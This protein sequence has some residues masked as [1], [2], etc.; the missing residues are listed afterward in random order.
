[1]SDNTPPAAT[2]TQS[3]SLYQA[4]SWVVTI[5]V[6]VALILT[7]VRLLMLP[8][9]LDFEYSTPNFPADSYGFTKQDRL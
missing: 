1:M 7:A 6:P 2:H 5:L 3:A 4:L 9:F 8:V